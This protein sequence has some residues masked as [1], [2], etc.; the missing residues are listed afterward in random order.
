MTILRRLFTRIAWWIID[1]AER[2]QPDFIV[3][4]PESP[5]LLRWWLVP[6]NRWFNVYLHHFLRDDDDRALHDHP[7][8]WCSILMVGSYIEHT[9]AAGGIHRR[10]IREAPSIKIS[11][12]WRAHRIELLPNT[13]N[14][15]NAFE[16]WPRKPC[17]TLFIT[18][19]RI[20]DWGFH[21]PQR[22]WVHYRDFT[23]PTDTGKTGAGCDG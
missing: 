20:R 8:F 9:V 23:D 4:G 21:C 6:R 17:W 14:P 11:G 3:G 10:Q 13:P 12:P 22:G 1:R 5:Y 16:T 15:A 19:P 18:G 7:W 2:R